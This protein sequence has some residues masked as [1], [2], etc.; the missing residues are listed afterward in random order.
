[1]C[2]RRFDRLSA[3]LTGCSLVMPN[4]FMQAEPLAKAIESE[5]VTISAA[6][7]TIWSDLLKYA[8]E[9]SPDLSRACACTA[10]T[11]VGP[12]VG[13]PWIRRSTRPAAAWP[14]Q[15]TTVARGAS[16]N[17]RGGDGL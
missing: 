2:R 6:V 1:M 17:S 13:E 15:R 7:P 9:H 5:K 10:A 3:G 12:W 4:K 8:N 11:S 14:A 16:R